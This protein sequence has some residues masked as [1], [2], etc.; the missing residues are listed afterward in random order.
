VSER[1]LRTA[2]LGSGGYVGQH[3][4]RLLAN[5][6]YFEVPQ[7]FGSRPSSSRTLSKVWRLGGDPPHNLADEKITYRTPRQIAHDGVDVVFSAL[8]SG[9]AARI[10]SELVRRGVS[11]FTNAADHRMDASVPLLVPEVNPAHLSLLAHRPRGGG[12][13]VAN[14]NCSVTGLVL[15]LA[16]L[17]RLLRARRVH[18][19]TFQARSGAGISGLDSAEI[20]RNVVPFIPEEEE[21]LERESQRILTSATGGRLRPRPLPIVAHCGRVD[22]RDGHLEAVTIEALRRPTLNEILRAWRKFD[23][24]AGRA[25][26]TAPHPP[27]EVRGAADRPQPRLD[28]WA[29]APSRA[30]GMAVVVGRPRWNPPFFRFFLLL[31]NAVRGG[32]GG[33]VLNAELATNLGWLAPRESLREP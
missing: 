8:P 16:P 32:A 10:E 5:H 23:P 1:T 4:A 7:L 33:S 21:K 17:R 18:V 25:L 27:I 28:V 19:T 31:H 9:S 15:A 2:I 6:P 14:P 30:R 20:S 3:F 22:V 26:P 12:I 24:L 29:G 13:L 11:V